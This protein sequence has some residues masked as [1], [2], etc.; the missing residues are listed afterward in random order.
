MPTPL[1]LSFSNM[2]KRKKGKINYTLMKAIT[3]TVVKKISQEINPGHCTKDN[4]T[5][6]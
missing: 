5:S 1:F 4:H 2:S 6:N 3:N